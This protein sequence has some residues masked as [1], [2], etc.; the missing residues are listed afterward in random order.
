M[1]IY[2]V[3]FSVH[4]IKIIPIFPHSRRECSLAAMFSENEY[5]QKL[6]ILTGINYVNNS[7][8]GD[9]ACFLSGMKDKRFSFLECRVTYNY[10]F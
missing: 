1:R 3:H 8:F 5:C 4:C 10:W 7:F 6:L 2:L 9:I